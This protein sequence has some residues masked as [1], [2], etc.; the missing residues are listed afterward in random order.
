MTLYVLPMTVGNNAA[1]QEIGPR[2]VNISMP[3]N[4]GSFKQRNFL[5]LIFGK[6]T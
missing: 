3:T 6:L 2:N 5:K 4:K 1:D